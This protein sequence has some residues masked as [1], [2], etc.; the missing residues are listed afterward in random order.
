EAARIPLPP[1]HA[2]PVPIAA[3]PPTSARPAD[4]PPPLHS[5]QRPWAIWVGLAMAGGIGLRF[6][7]LPDFV[8]PLIVGLAVTAG[9]TL[10]L[11]L[12]L[13]QTAAEPAAQPAAG[14]T[15]GLHKKVPPAPRRK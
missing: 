7:Q 2:A 5:T 14:E 13:G 9:V 12:F 6:V 1:V 8:L 10:M 3:P 4:L 11:H 15:S